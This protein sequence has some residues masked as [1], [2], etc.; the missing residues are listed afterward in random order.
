MVEKLHFRRG[1]DQGGVKVGA[2]EEG[3]VAVL[4]HQRRMKVVS[5][6]KDGALV[7]HFVGMGHGTFVAGLGHQYAAAVRVQRVAKDIE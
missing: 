5:E 1:A 4:L 7:G 2:P 3:E 6:I